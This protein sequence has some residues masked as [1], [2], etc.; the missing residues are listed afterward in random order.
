LLATLGGREL[1]DTEADLLLHRLF[2]EHDLRLFEG[3]PVRFGCRCGPERIAAL[4]RSLGEDE[5]QDIVAEQGAITVTCEFCHR[6]YRYDAIDVSQLFAEK[7]SADA[8]GS[9]N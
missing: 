5:A 7:P 6:P 8:P 4:L 9:V 1:L 3:E 2:A